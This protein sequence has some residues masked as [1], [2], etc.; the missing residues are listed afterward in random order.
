MKMRVVGGMADYL[1]DAS[2]KKTLHDAEDLMTP[3]EAAELKAMMDVPVTWTFPAKYSAVLANVLREHM[4]QMAM[5]MLAAEMQGDDESAELMRAAGGTT[6]EVL[7][8]LEKADP[9]KLFD[10]AKALRDRIASRAEM[11]NNM[12]GGVQ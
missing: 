11:V 6:L 8:S 5:R 2:T 10:H 1:S 9:G 3:T 7:E 12:K 4:A